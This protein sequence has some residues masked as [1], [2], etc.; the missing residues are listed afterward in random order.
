MGLLR[1]LLQCLGNLGR[2]RPM[3]RILGKAPLQQFRKTGIYVGAEADQRN[4]LF[5]QV[6]RNQLDAR[7]AFV[8]SLQRKKLV[9]HD[10]QAVHVRF[11]RD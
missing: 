6:S 7:G 11:I 1:D 3:P 8:R 9:T 10:A 2:P 5:L 4:W